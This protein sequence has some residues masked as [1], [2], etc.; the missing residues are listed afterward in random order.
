MINEIEIKFRKDD[1]TEG[2]K[3]RLTKKQRE[4]F[5]SKKL[6]TIVCRG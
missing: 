4:H 2:W 6:V 3:E 1:P 5:K